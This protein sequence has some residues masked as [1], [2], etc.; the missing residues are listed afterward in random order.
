MASGV[1]VIILVDVLE[2]GKSFLK[3]SICFYC[4]LTAFLSVK[5][6]CLIILHFS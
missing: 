4:V 3:L 2:A 5:K 6:N 1:F